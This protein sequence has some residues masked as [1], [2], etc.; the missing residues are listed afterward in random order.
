MRTE[1]GSASACTRAATFGASPNTSPL[2][3]TMTGPDSMPTRAESSG[4]PLLAF[5]ALISTSALDCERCA[6]G[7]LGVVLLRVRIAE[8]GHQP[9]A[10]FLQHVAAQPCHCFRRLVEIGVDHIAPVFRVEP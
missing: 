7:A 8:E 6:H 3:S 5:L 1:P 9:V 4:A 2:A 10:E